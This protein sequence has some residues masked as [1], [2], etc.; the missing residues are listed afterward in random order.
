MKRVILFDVNETL[1]DLS[2][3]QPHFERVFGDSSV[4]AQ[5]FAVL[6]HTSVVTTVTDAYENFGASGRRSA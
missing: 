3:L 5:W 4:M 2:V 6:L 1:L